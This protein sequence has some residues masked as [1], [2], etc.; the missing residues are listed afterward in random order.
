MLSGP[1]AALMGVRGMIT[2]RLVVRAKDVV[3]VKGM[4][5]AHDGLAHVFAESGGDL[6]IA[7]AAGRDAELDDLV[8]RSWPSSSRASCTRTVGTISWLKCST[9]TSPS[10]AAARRGRAPRCTSCGRRDEA[11]TRIV[12]LD[13]AKFPRDKPCA[14]AVSQLGVDVLG[15]IGVDVGVPSVPM[16][17]VRVLSGESVGETVD[18]MGVVI[19]RTEFDTHL[20]RPRGATACT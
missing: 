20:S 10:S 12:M 15:A 3:F 1:K 5:E 14:G 16:N 17:G 4:V 13:K 8:E 19:R 9:M 6:T 18:H 11:G 7:A 2:R